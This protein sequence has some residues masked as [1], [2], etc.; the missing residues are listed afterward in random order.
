MHSAQLRII[1]AYLSTDYI[2]ISLTNS[3]EVA[4]GGGAVWKHNTPQVDTRL[5]FIPEILATPLDSPQMTF[6]LVLT[7]LK[8][9]GESDHY[10]SNL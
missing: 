1:K 2:I 8:M 7:F 9:A 4:G 6:I 5:V 3:S 10:T